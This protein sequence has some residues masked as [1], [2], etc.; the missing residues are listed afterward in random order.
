MDLDRGTLAKI[1]RKVLSGLGHDENWQMVRVPLSKA[2]WS[3]WKRYCDALGISMG[4]AIATLVQYELR[5]VME[6]VDDG[7]V[8]LARLEEGVADRQRALDARERTL[9][10]REQ[11]LRAGT[12]LIRRDLGI[13]PAPTHMTKVGRN[14]PCPCGSGLKYKR[15]HGL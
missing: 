14:D 2:V 4:R 1:D 13:R 11:G 12:S 10:I 15:C 7:P 3:A 8:F 5:S 9:E 6:N